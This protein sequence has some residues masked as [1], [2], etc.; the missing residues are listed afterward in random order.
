MYGTVKDELAEVIEGPELPEPQAP[1]AQDPG[2]Q[3]EKP[4]KVFEA[5]FETSDPKELSSLYDK[6][7]SQLRG[8]YFIGLKLNITKTNQQHVLKITSNIEGSPT[9]SERYFIY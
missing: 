3:A 8:Q 2:A 9:S 7:D 5:V 4:Y 6:V 1:A